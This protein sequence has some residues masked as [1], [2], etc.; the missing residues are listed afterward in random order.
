MIEQ[1]EDLTN[2]NHALKFQLKTEKH[3]NKDHEDDYLAVW[4]LIKQPNETVVGAAKRIKTELA[5]VTKQRDD[6]ADALQRFVNRLQY[7]SIYMNNKPTCASV[8]RNPIKEWDEDCIFA[9]EVL[10]KLKGGDA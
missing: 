2:E 5:E 10:E 8:N 6:L 3:L 7:N 4:K 1:I 9:F